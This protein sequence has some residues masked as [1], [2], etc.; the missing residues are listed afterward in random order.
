[1]HI[2]IHTG[3]KKMLNFC[4][5]VTIQNQNLKQDELDLF[6]KYCL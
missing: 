1:M 5:K 3:E 2:S 6:L 4:L